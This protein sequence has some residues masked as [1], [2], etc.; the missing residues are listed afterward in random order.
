[1]L[2][3]ISIEKAREILLNEVL[4][5][6]VIDMPILESLDHILAEDIKSDMN[7]P[8]FDRT[9]LD[10][11][12]LRSEDTVSAGAEN[13]VILEAIDNIQAGYVSKK[14]IGKGQAIRIMTGAKIPKG[15]DAIIKYED[16]V[17]TDKDVKIFSHIEPNSNIVR[18]GEDIAVGDTILKQ[19]KTISPADIGILATLGRGRVKVYKRPKVAILST[20]DELVNIDEPLREGKIRNSNSYTIGAQ[21]KKLGSEIKI[22]GIC[23]DDIQTI[24]KELNPALEWG[25]IVITTGGVSV[26]DADVVKEAFEAVGGKILF[27][28]VRMKPGSPIAVAKYG[29]KLLFGLS[30]NPAAAYITFEKFVRPTILKLGGETRYDFTKVKSTLESEYTKVSGKNRIVRAKTYYKNGGFFTELPDKH[31]SGIL[32]SLS[33]TNSLFYIPPG[34]GPY[35]IGDSI[36]VELLDYLEVSE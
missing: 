9:P 22:F 18:A 36:E 12:A 3:N 13:P 7:M 5:P 6:K 29:D 17:F 35:R 28:G 11:Y 2:A 14:T 10:G 8:P 25:D 20:G 15:A 27:W 23:D 31:S 19:G 21:V 1:M 32:S 26:G 24:K 30:G 16:T 33:E 34:T 4:K